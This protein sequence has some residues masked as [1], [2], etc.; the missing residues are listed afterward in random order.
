M[1][2]LYIKRQKVFIDDEDYS[3]IIDKNWHLQK[4]KGRNLY[5]VVGRPLTRNKM[6]L[7]RFI[8]YLHNITIPEN[9]E[10][11][12]INGNGLDN[13]KINLRAVTHQENIL[14]RHGCQKNSTTKAV[15]IQYIESLNKYR[16]YVCVNRKFVHIGLYDTIKEATEIRNMY[17]ET[18]NL[19]CKKYEYISPLC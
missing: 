18:N 5:H 9:M 14:N 12:H 15:G 16:S 3:F 4:N 19:K 11:D 7:H 17:I 13:R 6:L 10:I 2:T 1:K 8:Y